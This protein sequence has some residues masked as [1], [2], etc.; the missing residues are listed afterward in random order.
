MILFWV[1]IRVSINVKNSAILLC[2]SNEG[3]YTSID[4]IVDEVRLGTPVEEL[5]FFQLIVWNK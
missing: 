4:S 3:R 1:S 5:Y 2:S